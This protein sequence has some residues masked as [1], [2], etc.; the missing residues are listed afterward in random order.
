MEFE[1]LDVVYYKRRVSK[2]DYQ[3]TRG[4]RGEQ[5]LP[6]GKIYGFRKFDKVRYFGKEYFVKGRMSEG[7][8]VVF[9]NI[10]GDRIDFS[11]MPKGYKT[12]K[13]ANCERLSARRSCLFIRKEQNLPHTLS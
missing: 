13:L 9:M 12:P 7:G 3:L 10:F 6:T 11:Y 8:Y 5:K 1:P 4:I 2:G